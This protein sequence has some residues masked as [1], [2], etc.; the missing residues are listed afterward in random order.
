MSH[1]RGC[2][3]GLFRLAI[4]NPKRRRART[5][6]QLAILAPPRSERIASAL[7]LV[8]CLREVLGEGRGTC[9]AKRA[10]AGIDSS[11]AMHFEYGERHLPRCRSFQPMAHP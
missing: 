7:V 10:Q 11:N 1:A 8:P 4:P 6:R 3:C 9:R 2:D 5:A